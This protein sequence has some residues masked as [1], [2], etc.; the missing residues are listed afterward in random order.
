MRC[1]FKIAIGSITPHLFAV[2]SGGGKIILPGISSLGTILYNHS[3]P[4]DAAVKANYDMNPVPLDMSEAAMF[5]HLD[6]NIEGLVNL[7]GETT[8]IFAREFKQSH[9]LCFKCDDTPAW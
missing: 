6:V 8:P 7:W 2:F 3:L 4:C 1:D 9:Q 5:A